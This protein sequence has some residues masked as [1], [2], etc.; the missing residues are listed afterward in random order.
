M[1]V[2]QAASPAA[3]GAAPSL[4]QTINL[5]QHFDCLTIA[6]SLARIIRQTLT[7]YHL[8]DSLLR[9]KQTKSQSQEPRERLQ[10]YIYPY[11]LQAWRA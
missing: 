6:T 9:L 8:D 4:S 7:E 2:L 11:C 5:S 1:P 10:L 3:F